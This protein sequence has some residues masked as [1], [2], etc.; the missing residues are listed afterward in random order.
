MPNV[1]FMIP[2]EGTGEV[3]PHVRNDSIHSPVWMWGKVVGIMEC[4]H[5]HHNRGNRNKASQ[6]PRIKLTNELRNITDIMAI[7]NHQDGVAFVASWIKIPLCLASILKYSLTWNRRASPNSLF[8]MN[9]CSGIPC[10]SSR[11]KYACD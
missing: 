8:Y 6:S 5:S 9:G 11:V 3:R 7:S 2:S 10:C 4:I 1:V